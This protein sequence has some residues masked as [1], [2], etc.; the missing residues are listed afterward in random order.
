MLTF[1]YIYGMPN[2]LNSDFE[3]HKF[4]LN[5][6]QRINLGSLGNTNYTLEGG[7]I[8]NPLPYPLLQVHTG[9]ESVFYTSA[10]FNLMDYMEFVSDTYASLRVLHNFDGHVMN[11]IPAIRKLNLRLLLEANI[12]YGSL[13]DENQTLLNHSDRENT[14]ASGLGTLSDTPYVELGYGIENILRFIR[15]DFF[16][17]LTYL[18]RPDVRKFGFKVSGQFAF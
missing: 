16:H 6:F 4:S 10:A 7:Q 9:N 13:S 11:K 15:I 18:D 12:L 2:V 1:R 8:L 5:A 14:L 17:R 3:Y